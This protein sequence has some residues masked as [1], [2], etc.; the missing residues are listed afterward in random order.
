MR[1]YA[2]VGELCPSLVFFK[3]RF[4]SC[5]VVVVV[6]VDVV[7]LLWLLLPLLLLL[8]L[9]SPKA[10]KRGSKKTN[11]ARLRGALQA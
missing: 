2:S 4:E 7:L 8:L 9:F 1:H 10:D 5:V 3:L 6:V 11:I